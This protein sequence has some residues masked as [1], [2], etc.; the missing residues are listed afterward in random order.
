MGVRGHS[1]TQTVKRDSTCRSTC[2]ESARH[3]RNT[4]DYRSELTIGVSARRTTGRRHLRD[5]A[6]D[7]CASAFGHQV[8]DPG[9]VVRRNGVC[10]HSRYP[11]TACGWGGEVDNQNDT[12]PEIVKALLIGA[13][14]IYLILMFQF[15]SIVDLVIMVKSI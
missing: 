2:R 14:A 11:G 9:R 1:I 15:R 13:A 6:G 4:V 12:F 3:W 10:I 5:L 7:R 8:W